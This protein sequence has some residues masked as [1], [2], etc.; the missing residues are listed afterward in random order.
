MTARVL[1]VDDI[2]ANVRLLQARLEAEYFEVVTASSGQE[3]LDICQRERV[4]VVLLDVMMPGMDGFEVCRRL[5]SSPSTLHIPVVMVTALDQV[6]D[7]VQG[8]DCGADDFLTKP[9]DDIALVTR[10]KSLARLKMLNDEMLM[11]VSTSRE[12]G[13]ADDDV[14][15]GILSDGPGRVLVIDDHPRSSSRVMSALAKVHEAYIEPDPQI[16]LRHLAMQPFDLLVVALSL[17]GMDGLRLCSQVRSMDRTRHLPILIMV[18]AGDEA[19]LLRGLDMGVND[20]LMRPVDRHELL[21]RVKTQI[22]RKR[23]S[24]YL[25]NRL[26]ES[27]ELSVSDPLTGLHN[28][29]YMERHLKTL[30]QDALRSRRSL[31]VLIADIDHFKNVNDTYGHDAGD[32]VLKEFSDRFRRY[33]RSVDLACRL[34]GEEFL[35]IMPDTDPVLAGQIGERVRACVASEPFAIGPDRTIWVTASVGLATWEGDHDT[36]EALFKRA[37]NALYTAKRQGRNQVVSDAA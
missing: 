33:T 18:D 23:F 16:A 32:L 12:M 37:D 15:A 26:R 29:R 3:A 2:L 4:D 20:Y 13:L 11:R 25:R 28:R 14:L 8:L 10:V 35:I 9:V 7:K 19:R 31:S 22:R 5:K 30:I 24:D 36:A 27:V 34:G 17:E 21:A 1:V 6:S